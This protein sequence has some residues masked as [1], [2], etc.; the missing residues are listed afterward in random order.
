MHGVLGIPDKP[1]LPG[2]GRVAHMEHGSAGE[3]RK[4]LVQA[5]TAEIRSQMHGVPVLRRELQLGTV[6]VVHQ[7]RYP[8][9]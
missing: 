2:Q 1:M 6:G 7:Q 9:R 8:Y 3:H 5:V 4:G